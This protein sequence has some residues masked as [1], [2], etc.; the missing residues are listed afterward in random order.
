MESTQV[1]DLCG[2]NDTLCMD[3]NKGKFIY[4]FGCDMSDKMLEHYTQEMMFECDISLVEEF[5]YSF[6]LQVKQRE[7]ICVSQIMSI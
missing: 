5:T 4:N 1:K 6:G 3:N 7:S 2:R